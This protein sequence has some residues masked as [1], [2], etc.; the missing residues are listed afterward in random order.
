MNHHIRRLVALL[1]VLTAVAVPAAPASPS[2]AATPV[3][4]AQLDASQRGALDALRAA[5]EASEA[6]EAAMLAAPGDADMK[7]AYEQAGR[8]LQASLE[9]A[10]ALREAAG[11]RSSEYGQALFEISGLAEDGSAEAALGLVQRWTEQTREWV[12]NQGPGVIVRL[13][14]FLVILAVFKTLAS[15]AGGVVRKAL[16]T[17]K[18]EASD[19]LKRFFV[20][21]AQ[22]VVF[23]TG[24]VIALE[25]IGVPVAPLLAG[26]GVVGFIVG[27]ALQDTLANFAAG[28]MILLYRPYDIG[29][30]ISA[31][32][33]SGT[34]RDMNL[35]STTITT[36]DNQVLILPNS[37]IWG[38]VIRNVTRQDTRRV[39]MTIGVSYDADLDRTIE[40][41]SEVVNAHEKVL[42]DPAPVI[43]VVALGESS[44]DLVVRPW[45]KTSDYWDVHFDL[46][47]QIKERL[48]AEGIG[49]P[50]PQ[51][52]LRVVSVPAGL[53]NGA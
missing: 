6:A 40:V 7:A 29:Q 33:E 45:A 31:A 37:S 5:V 48:D 23:F 49:I 32:G 8:D 25:Q 15:I 19:L 9:A 11:G 12:V 47:K 53:Q 4:A 3:V 51:R 36:P 24:L 43:R 22:K 34:V 38:G 13:L 26:V 39:D 28:V 20:G 14:V 21:L 10:R 35:V 30:F 41:I 1:L 18:V 52:D 42:E 2:L 16:S 44:V 46:H 27:F 17:S 50:F